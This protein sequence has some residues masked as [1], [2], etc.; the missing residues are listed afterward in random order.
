[1]VCER[2][3]IH[4]FV[5]VLD[6][7]LVKDN[8]QGQDTASM[9]GSIVGTPHYMAPEIVLGRGA[10][11][12]TD[13]YAL[14]AVGYFMLTGGVVFPDNTLL[15]VVAHHVSDPPEPPERTPRQ[16]RPGRPG[17]THLALPG[18]D[19][20]GQARLRRRAARPLARL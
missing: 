6:F 17:G 3:G 7:G 10:S 4:D 19:G 18:Q 14:G 13:L 5:K 12:S 2:G 15:G 8:R 9:A 16:A 20:R 11:A 1:M